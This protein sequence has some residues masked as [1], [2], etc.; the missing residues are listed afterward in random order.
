MRILFIRHGDPNYVNDS[1]TEL[2]QKEATLLAERVAELDPEVTAYYVSPLGRARET[3]EFC[4]KPLG[5]EATVLP[6]VEEFTGRLIDPQ[7]GHKRIAWDFLPY[8]WM[9][10]PLCY[11]KNGWWNAKMYAGSNSE[12]AYKRIVNGFDE[13][14]ASY[15]Y[16]RKCPVGEGV[17]HSYV[18]DWDEFEKSE[19]VSGK[20]ATIVIFCH[21]IA[22]FACLSHV[23]GVPFPV[24]AHGFYSAPTGWNMIETEERVEGEAHFRIR[25]IGDI[26]HLE[27]YHQPLNHSGFFPGVGGC[28][29]NL[30]DK[31][32][33]N[34]AK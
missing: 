3:A 6:W 22:T 7:D 9:D 19:K 12:V 11:D 18:T 30:M 14:V 15:G 20:E 13:L 2:G 17:T 27:R 5:K 16:Q 8:E 32:E 10:D 25:S 34:S 33:K 1:L 4:L 26:S 24:F 28:A 21:M 29:V 23:T 31:A